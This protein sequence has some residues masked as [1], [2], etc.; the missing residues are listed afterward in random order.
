MSLTTGRGP[1]SAHPAGRFDVSIPAPVTYAEPF[2]RRVTAVRD[3][4]VVVD[5]EQ[6]A[7]VHRPGGPPTWAFPE[8]DVRDVETVA[9]PLLPGFVVVAWG[10]VDGWF[11][12]GAPVHMHPRNPYHRVDVIATRRRLRVELLGLELV[13]TDDTVVVYETALEPLLYVAK[14]CVLPADVLEPSRTTTYCPYKGVASYW[15]AR[16]GDREV[17]DVAWSYE[18]PL[19]ECTGIRGLLAFYPDR[20]RVTQDLPPAASVFGRRG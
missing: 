20:A 11:E 16:V 10:A 17:V 1:L 13:N 6:V 9:V 7:L 3:G 8:A 4:I 5:S 2:R 18:D 12:E 14:D 15:S 19:P